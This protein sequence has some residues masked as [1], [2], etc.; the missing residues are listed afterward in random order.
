M[1]LV[2]GRVWRRHKLSVCNSSIMVLAKM[3]SSKG[4]EDGDIEYFGDW[5]GGDKRGRC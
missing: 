4:D 3:S 2:G 5:S 1:N